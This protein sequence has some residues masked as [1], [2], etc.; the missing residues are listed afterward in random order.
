M[1]RARHKANGGKTEMI[2]K[3]RE[4]DEEK[5]MEAGHA[6]GGK[7]K[8]ARGGKTEMMGEGMKP[9]NHRLDRPGRKRGGSVGAD[10][11]PLSS[12]ANTKDAEGH[13]T[14]DEESD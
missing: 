4:E 6:K 7:V 14:D 2:D 1:S 8:R 9:K 3:G 11:H 13:S 12:A 5:E 10:K